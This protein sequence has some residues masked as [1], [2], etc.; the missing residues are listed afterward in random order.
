MHDWYP[1][2]QIWRSTGTNMFTKVGNTTLRV[3]DGSDSVTY[4]EYNLTTPLNFQA[5]DGLGIFQPDMGKNRLR[6]Y[7]LSG[8]GPQN[9]Y[10]TLDNNDIVEPP[11]DMFALGTV[12]QNDLPLITV[13][14]CKLDYHLCLVHCMACGQN[15]LVIITL[16]LLKSH[17]FPPTAVLTTSSL[18]PTLP[19]DPTSLPPPT[20]PAS[21][22]TSLHLEPATTLPRS[23]EPYAGSVTEN[24]PVSSPTCSIDPSNVLGIPMDAFSSHSALTGSLMAYVPTSSPTRSFDPSN[25][26]GMPMD[27][28]SSHPPFSGPVTANVPACSPTCSFNPSS[29]PGMPISSHPRFA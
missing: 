29:V 9:Y 10:E 14:I 6:M 21:T 19:Y 8:V 4:Y 28:W 27:V 7:F 23:T 25:V 15:S 2:L 16:A 24:V 11:T 12:F 3:E 13:E 26:P 17:C 1:D 18:V 22:T 5:G 20:L